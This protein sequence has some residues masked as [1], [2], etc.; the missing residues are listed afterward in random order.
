[1]CEDLEHLGQLELNCE[2]DTNKSSFLSNL[3][4]GE[5]DE[6]VPPDEMWHECS[7]NHIDEQPE[8]FE[9]AT[10]ATVINLD[11]KFIF[12]FLK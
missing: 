3:G 2:G 5:S 11:L 8:D 1:M 6:N 10:E 4:L 7:E 9:V 12:I